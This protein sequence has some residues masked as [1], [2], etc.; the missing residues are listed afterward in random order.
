MS[1]MT[2]YMGMRG[3]PFSEKQL[4]K[5][6]KDIVQPYNEDGTVNKEFESLYPKSEFITKYER[7]KRTN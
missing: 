5:H 6:A 1:K 7:N 4:E 2:F 3:R